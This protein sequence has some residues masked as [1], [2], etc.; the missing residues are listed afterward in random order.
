MNKQIIF[1]II[2]Y[3]IPCILIISF[4]IPNKVHREGMVDSEKLF[5]HLLGNYSSYQFQKNLVKEKALYTYATVN[6]S[7]ITGSEIDAIVNYLQQHGWRKV[8]SN[9]SKYRLCHGNQNLIAITE[10]SNDSTLMQNNKFKG[11]V[12]FTFF[13]SYR[14]TS[15]C[16]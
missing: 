10:W 12:E 1:K 2:Y 16:E 4:M 8:V 9:E 11:K 3:T 14:G 13:Y 7:E 6:V 15:T 5:Y